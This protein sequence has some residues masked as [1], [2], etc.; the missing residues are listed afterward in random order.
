MLS[1]NVLSI[2]F[3]SRRHFL[4]VLVIV[5]RS[6]ESCTLLTLLTCNSSYM[7]ATCVAFSTL[8]T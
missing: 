4:A 1:I 8:M 6:K 5:V 3:K 2:D 7:K